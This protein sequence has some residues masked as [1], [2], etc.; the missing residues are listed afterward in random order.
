MDETDLRI[1]QKNIGWLTAKSKSKHAIR[2]VPRISDITESIDSIH[3]AAHYGT[4]KP[5]SPAG[6]Q[7]LSIPP[8]VRL[9]G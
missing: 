7:L 6:F 9:S 8:G 3:L 5:A 2:L 1:R 4:S